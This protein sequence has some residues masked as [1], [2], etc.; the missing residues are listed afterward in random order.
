[1]TISVLFRPPTALAALALACAAPA[2]A[3]TAPASPPAADGAASAPTQAPPAAFG[4]VGDA[5]DDRF[6]LQTQATLVDQFHPGFRSPYRGGSSLDPGVRGDETFD[7]TAFI[8]Y[9]P[10]T[11]GEI[12][13]D[14][15]IDQGF[16]L[17]DTLGV[18]DFPSAE[19]YK[20]GHP[21]PYLKI[22]RFFLRQTFNLGGEPQPADGDVNQFAGAPSAN[23][24]VLTV[25]KMS[26][27]DIFDTNAYAHDAK[28]DF[29]NWGLVD[30]GS[31]DYAADAWGFTFGAAAEWYQGDWTLR[32]GLYDLSKR[33]N[34]SN[35]DYSF[36]QF[37]VIGELER[38]FDI[39]GRKGALRVTGFATR[40]RMG[41]YDAA[42]LLAEETGQAAD[43]GLV[44]RY[45]T[46]PGVSLTFEQALS[47]SLGL[48]VRAGHAEGS[49]EG[50]DFTDISNT[51]AAGL[52]L[53]GSLWG[54]KDDVVGVAGVDSQASRAALAYF[55]AGGVGI[56]AGDGELP[57]P[58][59]EKVLETYYTLPFVKVTRLTFDYQFVDN[60]AFNRDRGPV[61]IFAF[62]IH[63]QL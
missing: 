38:R 9:R 35:V 1:M 55:A 43:T 42:V 18:D 33:P 59:A 49:Y 56:L 27:P 24:V 47:E 34:S 53:K 17:S 58:G 11:G 12:W 30:T 46:R 62:R 31:F 8:G 63:A 3:Q 23:R 57:H 10:W 40:G 6:A 19:A 48:F 39:F 44:R 45:R 4:L 26:V 7:L 52:A 15:E 60:P 21:Y 29:L 2:G 20:V 16:G 36:G 14:P 54:R 22:Q 41:K 61:S 50:F 28:N 25:G 37:Q 32:G 51:L 13:A 5:V